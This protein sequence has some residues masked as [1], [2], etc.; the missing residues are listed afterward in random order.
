[1]FLIGNNASF[2]IDNSELK[3]KYNRTLLG[4]DPDCKLNFTNSSVIYRAGDDINLNNNIV[5]VVLSKYKC[6]FLWS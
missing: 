6:R 5:S 3:L 1:M 2:D 4:L